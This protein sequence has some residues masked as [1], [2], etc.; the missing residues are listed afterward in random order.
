MVVPL[1]VEGQLV[2][3]DGRRLRGAATGS[4]TTRPPQLQRFADTVA[5]T[6]D[7]ARLQASERERRGWL[8]YIADAGDL[9]AGSLD[10][11]MTM[12][13][14][15]QIVVPRLAQW[16][17]IHLPT[18]AASRSLH[19]VWHEDETAGRAGAAGWSRRLPGD[20]LDG[21]VRAE[22]GSRPP[23]SPWSRAA[24]GSAS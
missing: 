19:Q 17:A 11:D 10:Q 15:G 12:A 20:Q 23:A 21:G 7:R 8:S 14:T 18:S 2:G 9:L 16:C 3:V 5:L 24:G 1:I 22:P 6:A 4:P 13:I